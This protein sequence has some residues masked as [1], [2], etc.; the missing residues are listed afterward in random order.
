MSNTFFTAF[1]LFAIAITGIIL[2]GCSK[3]DLPILNE[4][5]MVKYYCVKPMI[6]DALN[7]GSRWPKAKPEF[8]N[9]P[10]DFD[11]VKTQSQCDN[12]EIE[13]VFKIVWENV[14]ILKQLKETEEL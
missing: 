9:A 6:Y 5:K 11:I 14:E 2:T 10:F 1:T 3:V 12:E 7:V 4:T 13:K 8:V